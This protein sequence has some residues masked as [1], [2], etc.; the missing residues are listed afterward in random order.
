MNIERNNQLNFGKFRGAS[1][2][3]VVESPS[4]SEAAGGAVFWVPVEEGNYPENALV[5]GNDADG[6]PLYIGRSYHEG[7]LLPGKVNKA[8]N[9][10]YVA[11]VSFYLFVEYF[12]RQPSIPKFM[13]VSGRR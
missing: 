1:G 7:A 5:G 6:E 9:T 11:H 8:H 13:F 4:A 12:Y 10:C 3:W 2:S